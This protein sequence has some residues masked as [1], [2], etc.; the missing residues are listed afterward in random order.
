M[1]AVLRVQQQGRYTNGLEPLKEAYSKAKSHRLCTCVACC[2]FMYCFDVWTHDTTQNAFLCVLTKVKDP[3]FDHTCH[4]ALLVF[5][6]G[7]LLLV[8]LYRH[9]FRLDCGRQLLWVPHQH[10]RLWA[11]GHQWHH[12]H[13]LG[14]LRRLIHHQQR[15]VGALEPRVPRSHTR[16]S[17]HVTGAQDQRCSEDG[18]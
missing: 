3:H 10:N 16:S 5:F 13:R 9:L 17:H 7:V 18:M 4:N 14:G 11:G 15:K 1:H 12:G 2:S 6:V 8:M